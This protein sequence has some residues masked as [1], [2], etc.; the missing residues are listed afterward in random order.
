VAPGNPAALAARNTT[1]TIP[2]VFVGSDPVAAGLVAS[3]SRPG[4]NATGVEAFVLDLSPKRLELLRELLPN[5]RSV[6]L[7]LHPGNPYS[8]NML[9]SVKAAASTAGFD[10]Q[11]LEARTESEIEEA[12]TRLAERRAEALLVTI[13]PL[14]YAQREQ[15]AALAARLAIPAV[16]ADQVFVAAG[17]LMSYGPDFRDIWRLLGVYAGK[18]LGGAKPAD[19]PVQ[20]PTKLELVIN[21]KAATA[22]GLVMPPS[23]LT[24]AEEVIE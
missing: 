23:L 19:L 5:A 21:L 2:I 7:I 15:I 20:R 24:R 18:I 4:G 10:I 17:G 1:R 6:G 12:F 9:A 3:F 22:L 14:F 8:A 13:D 11:V 16:Y